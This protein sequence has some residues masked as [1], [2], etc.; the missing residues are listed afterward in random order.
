MTDL[1]GSDRPIN[2]MS[3]RSVVVDVERL[4]AGGVGLSEMMA[5]SFLSTVACLA[6]ASRSQSSSGGGANTDELSGSLLLR[7]VG[8]N[9][10]VPMSSK[11]AAAVILPICATMLSW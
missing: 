2:R 4:V 3:D 9:P 5:A 6:S 1:S 11:A 10:N 8:L 7:W